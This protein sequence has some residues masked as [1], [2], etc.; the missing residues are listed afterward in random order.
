MTGKELRAW[1]LKLGMTQR[2]FSW[3]IKPKRTEDIISQWELGKMPVPEWLD[4]LKE[5]TDD[6]HGR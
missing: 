6:K 1:R 5:Y 4:T 2:A 3:W